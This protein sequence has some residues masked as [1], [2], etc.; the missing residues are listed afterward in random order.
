[1]AKK[2]QEPVLTIIKKSEGQKVSDKNAVS[3]ILVKSDDVADVVPDVDNV[4]DAEKVVET[5]IIDET[6]GE[7]ELTTN[8]EQTLETAVDPET[9]E[10][11]LICDIDE[12]TKEAPEK[13]VEKPIA[14]K[15]PVEPELVKEETPKTVIDPENNE[16]DE[17]AEPPE[18]IPEELI[19]PDDYFMSMANPDPSMEI[20][21]PVTV[22]EIIPEN[23]ATSN[24]AGTENTDL[25]KL[26]QQKQERQAAY[27]RYVTSSENRIFYPDTKVPPHATKFA[28]QTMVIFNTIWLF[29]GIFSGDV[30]Q[31]VRDTYNPIS[32]GYTKSKEYTDAASPINS[33]PG[34]K[35][36]P[37]VKG[38]FAPTK[39]WI[40]NAS[41]MFIALCVVI[42]LENKRR[43]IKRAFREEYDEFKNEI[44][45]ARQRERDEKAT[46]DFMLNLKK[47]GFNYHIDPQT[48]ERLVSTVIY[49]MARE[50]SVYFEMLK[51]GDIDLEKDPVLKN[52]V[53]TIARQH[54]GN[55]Q[56][57][58]AEFLSKIGIKINADDILNQYIHTNQEIERE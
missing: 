23:S 29:S 16:F 43:K 38:K 48:A 12:T 57:D 35:Y 28:V 21:D 53:I 26:D 49:S 30:K 22:P 4:S 34:Y 27:D 10:I 58:T 25:D 51:N 13:A 55:N 7:Q 32:N 54:F 45:Q 3:Q 42:G 17:I 56:A 52:V 44:R 14:D 39:T 8:K 41:A 37:S 31:Y 50:E 19:Y 2:A 46:V 47:L 18:E 33:K 9:P 6:V 11:D 40:I 1:M 5:P 15:I 24:D 20:T 36:V